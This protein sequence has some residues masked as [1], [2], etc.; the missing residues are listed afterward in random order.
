[1][2]WFF[3]RYIIFFFGF[4]NRSKLLGSYIKVI[5]HLFSNVLYFVLFNS[6]IT[7]YTQKVKQLSFFIVFPLEAYEYL[8][9]LFRSQLSTRYLTCKFVVVTCVNAVNTLWVYLVVVLLVLLSLLTNYVQKDKPLIILF[10]IWIIIVD[11]DSKI[12]LCIHISSSFYDHQCRYSNTVVELY[13]LKISKSFYS[14]NVY[15]MF[16]TSPPCLLAKAI[17]L[18]NFLSFKILGCIFLGKI[19]NLRCMKMYTILKISVEENTKIKEGPIGQSTR[20]EIKDAFRATFEWLLTALIVL[21]Q[22]LLSSSVDVLVVGVLNL[23]FLIRMGKKRYWN[24]TFYF[25]VSHQTLISKGYKSNELLNLILRGTWFW[26][27][28]VLRFLLLC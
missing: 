10:V 4:L 24:T 14:K 17:I 25:K 12:I 9:S 3:W 23:P 2:R 18:H 13:F 8:L 20:L 7:F 27:T 6:K 1:M 22:D 26:W 28:W 5:F 11:I 16:C 19:Y 15:F 21:L